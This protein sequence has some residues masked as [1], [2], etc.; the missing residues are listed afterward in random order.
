MKGWLDGVDANYDDMLEIL[1][2]LVELDS[3]LKYDSNPLYTI[4]AKFMLAGR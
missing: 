1:D 2:M 4:E 3:G